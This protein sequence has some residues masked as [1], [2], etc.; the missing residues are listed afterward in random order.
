MTL[1]RAACI[2][3]LAEGLDGVEVYPVRLPI[4]PAMPAIVLRYVSDF[5]GNVHD[6]GPDGLVRK[7]LQV[8]IYG[9]DHDSSDELAGQVGTLLDGYR[10]PW[11][12]LITIG[13]CMKDNEF[14]VDEPETG[15]WR[16]VQDYLVEYNERSGS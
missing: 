7:R 9:Q 8:D 11:G 2:E 1:L 10:G 6:R 3:F 16:R 5:T 14:D 15:L 4:H 13:A 12:A